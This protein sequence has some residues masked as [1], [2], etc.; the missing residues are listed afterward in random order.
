MDMNENSFTV[1]NGV[2]LEYSGSADEIVIP[3]GVCEIAN[4]AFGYNECRAVFIPASVKR[5]GRLAFRECENLASV[6]FGRG[7]LLE[8]IDDYAFYDCG[9]LEKIII[10]RG[11]RTI[12]ESAFE[13]CVNLSAEFAPG[14]ELE[15][16][17]KAAFNGC[18]GMKKIKIPASVK[19]IEAKAF[20]STG[21]ICIYFAS[22]SK[23]EAIEDSAFLYSDR[24]QQA[25]IEDI[26]AWCR[27]SFG[28]RANPLHSVTQLYINSKPAAELHIPE[29]VGSIGTRAFNGCKAIKSITL[30]EGLTVIGEHAFADCKSLA[31]IN[32][33][34][35]ITNIVNGA[36]SC[37][38]SLCDVK[39]P[40]G[41]TEICDNV[42]YACRALTKID[43]PSSLTAPI[44]A[45]DTVGKITVYD[46][47][48]PIVS[49]SLTAMQ[50]VEEEK[51]KVNIYDFLKNIF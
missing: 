4:N 44:T 3:E 30:P 24:I 11:V 39:L 34:S 31:N 36:F 47:D 43:I 51:Y 35:S 6:T 12:G 5:I 40:A 16:I 2:L 32:L 50:T 38:A 37:C 17:G 18:S 27:V 22:G 9:D 48:K 7:S 41:I 13:G 26:A 46:G 33:P 8:Y 1:K 15:V 45:G 19:K 14:A 42:F 10:P 49:Y 25:F 23:L 28:Y 29:G 21:I 20:A